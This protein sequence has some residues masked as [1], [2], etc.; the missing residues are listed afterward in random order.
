MS[1]GIDD[2]SYWKEMAFCHDQAI[3]ERDHTIMNLEE[4]NESVGK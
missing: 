2:I 1:S 3:R 4:E